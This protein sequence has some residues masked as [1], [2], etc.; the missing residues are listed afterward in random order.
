MERP[1]GSLADIVYQAYNQAI[2]VLNPLLGPQSL[3]S[4]GQ[5]Q[6]TTDSVNTIPISGNNIIATTNTVYGIVTDNQAIMAAVKYQWRPFRFFAG[7]EHIQQV[8]PVHP[9]GV[10]ALAQGAYFMSGVEDNNLDSPKIVQIW[11]TGVKYAINSENR[12]QPWPGII[13]SRTT[14]VFRQPA[15]PQPVSAVPA[16]GTSTRSRSI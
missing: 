15:P 12:R 9:L 4:A 1:T 10:G 11:W 8:N 2:S 3:S 14:S 16:R 7:Y 13:R 5:Y 6:S